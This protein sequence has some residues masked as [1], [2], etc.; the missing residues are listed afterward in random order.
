[1]LK[2]LRTK[3]YCIVIA[4][5]CA[6]LLPQVAHA[7]VGL[8]VLPRHDPEPPNLYFVTSSTAETAFEGGIDLALSQ[9]WP[10]DYGV[11]FR[12]IFKR[13]FSFSVGT[14]MYRLPKW[15]WANT[16]RN[17]YDPALVYDLW[18]SGAWYLPIRQ[19]PDPA[20][21]QIGV[22]PVVQFFYGPALDLT[23]VQPLFGF[24]H[25]WHLLFGYDKYGAADLFVGTQLAVESNFDPLVLGASL[26]V[27]YN[28]VYLYWQP[29]V[30]WAPFQT[31][32]WTHRHQFGVLFR[33]SWE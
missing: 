33:Y 29:R 18:M 25:Y 17:E 11:W 5:A 20:S 19:S 4:A 31:G 1:M 2:F 22:L 6:V 13:R 14:Q 3:W 30:F 24:G 8:A 21:L 10:L 32:G 7:S 16:P 23:G 12:G 26:Q 28:P 27:G 15:R 9:W